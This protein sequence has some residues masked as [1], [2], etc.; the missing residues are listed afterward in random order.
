MNPLDDRLSGLVP[1]EVPPPSSLADLRRRTTRRRTRRAAAGGALAATVLAGATLL[2]TDRERSVEVD[3]VDQP[4]TTST[5]APTTTVTE[6]EP[7]PDPDPA[8]TGE[9]PTGLV[10]ASPAGVT[11]EP[12]DGGEPVTVSTD[13][14]TVA[15]AVG[16]DVV[17]FEGAG[18]GPVRVWVD[19][20]V[21]PLPMAP[22]AGDAA[23]LDARLVDG[24]P[25]ALVFE[26]AVTPANP[27]AAYGELVLVDLTDRT[28]T[29]VDRKVGVQAWE[30]SYRS[31]RI[32]DD[33]DV[34]SVATLNAMAWLARWTPG[35]G[36]AAWTTELRAESQADVVLLGPAIATI[37]FELGPA[38][39]PVVVVTEHDPS[40]GEPADA[41]TVTIADEGVAERPPPPSRTDLTCIDALTPEVLTCARS[42]GSPVTVNLSSATFEALPGPQGAV[43]TAIR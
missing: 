3:V 36:E 21:E 5:V 22:E 29:T 9:M 28:R 13:P 12:V 6:P 23:L 19:D 32:L 27:D 33:G 35:A 20:T 40:T 37:D 16:D 10:L 42:G 38:F 4:A 2:F 11:V 26:R 25:T 30:E 15:Y 24:V 41:D 1:D 18:E 14:A 17:A 39:E 34:V 8:P 31:G 7:K 43:A